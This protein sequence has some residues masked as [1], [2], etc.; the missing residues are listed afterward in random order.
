M[1][2]NQP[3]FVFFYKNKKNA[4]LQS[5]IAFFYKTKP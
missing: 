3:F 2:Q 4:I 1:T 5:K